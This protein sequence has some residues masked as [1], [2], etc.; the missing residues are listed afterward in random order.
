MDELTEVEC[1]KCEKE[2]ETSHNKAAGDKFK[3]EH[4][5]HEHTAYADQIDGEYF[6][7]AT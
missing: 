3:C 1:L 6:W 4:C 7:Y 5:G 2:F